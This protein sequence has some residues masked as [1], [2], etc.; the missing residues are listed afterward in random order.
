MKNMYRGS[1][2]SKT[3]VKVTAHQTRRSSETGK[4]EYYQHDIS[5]IISTKSDT[6]STI[7]LHAKKYLSPRYRLITGTLFFAVRPPTS[8]GTKRNGHGR[9]SDSAHIR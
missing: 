4:Q 1:L 6:H 3:S 9:C 5:R 2:A 8:H 7:A